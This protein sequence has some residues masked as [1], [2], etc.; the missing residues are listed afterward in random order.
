MRVLGAVQL[1]EQARLSETELQ[2]AELA[3]EQVDDG[4]DVGGR[5]EDRVDA[6]DN[7]VCGE[8]VDG[9]EAAVEVYGGALE[10]DA[11]GETLGVA[12][13][14]GWLV[15]CGDGVAAEDAAG[16]VE[17]VGDVVEED[18]LEGLFGGLLVVFGDLLE[19]R[20]GGCEDGVVC[21]R[22]VEELDE[23]I[24]LIDQFGELGGVIALVDKL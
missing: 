14:M 4:C 6:V 2:C 1:V 20:V 9:N 7:A 23:V 22:A 15:E 13:V 24:V 11:H 12:E 21:F 5:H 17:V 10:G 16:G 3:R 8:D 19:G 18:V